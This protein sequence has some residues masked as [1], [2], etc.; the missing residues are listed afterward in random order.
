VQLVSE[1]VEDMPTSANAFTVVI[2]CL[3]PSLA[4]N[5]EYWH[6]LVVKNQ[7]AT[8]GKNANNFFDS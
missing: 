8:A 1:S 3:V 4:S 5:L 2:L 6:K 7:A